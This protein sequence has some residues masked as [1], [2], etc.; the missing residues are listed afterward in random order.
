VAESLDVVARSPQEAHKYLQHAWE[1]IGKPLT[2][3]SVPVHIKVCEA[4]L[5]RTLA[6][7]RFYWSTVLKQISQQACIDGQRWSVDAWHELFKRQFLGYEIIKFKV[8]GKKRTQ[9]KR[10]LKSTTKLKI[11]AF[12]VY[13]DKV[14]AFAVTDLSVQFSEDWFE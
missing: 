11:K 13:L 4:E 6:A 10:Q 8:A 1:V 2:L 14:I 3:Q 7:N 12:S 5:D 9:V